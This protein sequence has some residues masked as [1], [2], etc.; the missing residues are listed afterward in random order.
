[1]SNAQRHII[2][3]V[4]LEVETSQAAE[5]WGIQEELSQLLQQVAVP[6][7]EQ[8]F[9]QWTQTDEVVRL[10]QLVIDLPPIAPHNLTAEFVPKLLAGLQQALADLPP[11]L[12][13]QS[14]QP[15]SGMETT[16]LTGDRPPD[17][18]P[19]DSPTD[20]LTQTPPEADWE[21]LLYFLAYGRFPWW[22]PPA[23][24]STWIPRWQAVIQS[25]TPWRASLQQLIANQ[26]QA[27]Q[28]LVL[29]FPD[30]FQ[31]QLLLRM[32]PTWVSFQ[33]LFEAAQTLLRS[34]PLDPPTIRYLEQQAWLLLFTE[35]QSNTTIGT[36]LPLRQWLQNWLTVFLDGA[37]AAN[38][39]SQQ[40]RHQIETLAPVETAL[41]LETLDRVTLDLESSSSGR[42]AWNM[43][44]SRSRRPAW[45][46]DLEALPPPAGGSSPPGEHFQAEPGN[47]VDD[48]NDGN[49]GNLDLE[50]SSR[51]GRPAWNADLEALPPPAGGSSP[52]G[53]HFQAEPGNEVD[54][55]GNEVDEPGNEVD[56]VDEVNAVNLDRAIQPEADL[57]EDRPGVLDSASE[58]ERLE[59]ETE[60]AAIAPVE[61]SDVAEQVA[62][63]TVPGNQRVTVEQTTNVM[64]PVE[65]SDVIER[66]T[67]A[68]AP[69][70]EPD[71]I[72]STT[73][74]TVTVELSRIVE[75][76][77]EATVRG[78]SSNIVE[79]TME[80]IA[81]VQ[82]SMIVEP[83]A[84]VILSVDQSDTV[85]SAMEATV[86]E[87]S[88]NI[89]ELTT[90]AIAP[91][92][93]LNTFESTV[94]AIAS[95]DQLDT[96]ERTTE[97]VVP[98]EP[99]DVVV[100][101]T[102]AI[103]LVESSEIAEPG[104]EAIAPIQ[105]STLVEP[106]TEALVPAESFDTI[107]PTTEAIAPASPSGI[108]EPAVEAIVPV[109]SSDVAEPAVEAIVPVESSD[110]AEPAVE[111]I[112][113]V[114]SSDVAEPAVEAIV[115]VESSDVAEPAVEA[116]VPV[117]SS[118]VAEPAVEA[119]VPVESSDV[120]EPAVEVIVSAES[121]GVA[122]PTAE[123]IASARPS[124]V[125]ELTTE[126]T[127]SAEPS[128]VIERTVEP[129]TEAIAPVEQ[130]IPLAPTM[131]TPESIAPVESTPQAET[132]LQ[133]SHPL[134]ANPPRQAIA[135]TLSRAERAN[136]IYVSHA[137]VVL[138]HPFLKFYL[139]GV[140]LVSDNAF[141]HEYAQQVAIALLHY[142]ATRERTVPESA[143]V[144]PKLLCGWPLEQPVLGGLELPEAALAE[145]ENLLQTVINYWE[146][147]KNTSPD[148]LR[149]G[150]LQ[151][152][153][154]LTRS[155]TGN[156]KLRVEQQ[157]IDILLSRLP[158]GLSMVKLPWMT[159]VL[160]VEWI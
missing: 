2:G 128:D 151:R 52:P 144:L 38:I 154:K 79:P 29:Q 133:W 7:I 89:V 108:A 135:P 106:A 120:A 9:D 64:V 65:S 147:L 127:V 39:P 138:L 159:E 110:V 112:V 6:Q 15:F 102:E 19:I 53:E 25:D 157:S 139:E 114:E 14:R 74:A 16:Q 58:P 94:E 56:E 118:D 40:V 125:A 27:R 155:D 67:E 30:T 57:S 150:F 116:I 34:L 33:P 18:P 90:E 142:L 48:G 23:P 115:P 82:P 152:Q 103:V 11:P 83:V 8:L 13:S 51:S 17:W 22:Q 117:E 69:V 72:E 129:T 20:R 137:G 84:E 5:A 140:G 97:V 3:Q 60:P 76:V 21:V 80:A 31:Q 37:I 81:A 96:V 55:P 85:E 145:G 122:E 66:T 61:P 124:D 71:T 86:S 63:A 12:L 88:S 47:E 134:M 104:T 156:W 41:W 148:G 149:Q 42:P 36:P 45:N 4:I 158:W 153:G 26:P 92:D 101:T 73:E 32:Q 131:E 93:Q 10:E 49:D 146:V 130:D 70:D 119:I 91:A 24:L 59:S 109:E 1:M 78:T 54:E 77:T 105:P 87:T 44:I 136:G 99:S 35:I 160:V 68:I 50:S 46:A 75:P 132:Q 111:A 107:E 43:D 121:S 62:E 126:A 100:R 141:R 28:R 143:L 95:V 98:V 123:A 113:P